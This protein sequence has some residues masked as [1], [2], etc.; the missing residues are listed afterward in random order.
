MGLVNELY[1]PLFT[2]MATDGTGMMGTIVL[3]KTL[4]LLLP[5]MSTKDM[6]YR[7]LREYN[8]TPIG[9]GVIGTCHC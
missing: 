6:P 2:A 5:T 7:L 4:L 1:A 8:I 9:S 3:C